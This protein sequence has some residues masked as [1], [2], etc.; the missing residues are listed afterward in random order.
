M[1]SFFKEES[2]VS[3][4]VLTK[5]KFETVIGLG[6]T[7]AEVR[8]MFCIPALRW[9]GEEKLAEGLDVI[10]YCANEEGARHIMHILDKW[11]LQ[12]YQMPFKSVYD[13]IQSMT[14][15]EFEDCMLELG[16]R[17]NPSAIAIMNEVIRKKENSG[18][19]QVNF[20]NTLPLEGESDKEDD[21]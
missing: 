4:Y 12:E 8:R 16:I 20:V 18:I 14:V 21:E 2:I 7:L 15:K 1:S 11:C 13:L 19:V 17:G 3:G 10:D 6:G 9:N 5:Q